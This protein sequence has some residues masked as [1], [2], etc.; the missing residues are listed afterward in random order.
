MIFGILGKKFKVMEIWNNIGFEG[1]S[2][3]KF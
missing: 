3:L 2:K 1:S